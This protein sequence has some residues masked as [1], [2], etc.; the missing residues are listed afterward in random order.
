MVRHVSRNPNPNTNGPNVPEENLPVKQLNK[1]GTNFEAMNFSYV[2]ILMFTDSHIKKIL[3][4]GSSVRSSE[5]MGRI[6]L[7][8]VIFK[9]NVCRE[10]SKG[11]Y[12]SILLHPMIE[13]FL[14][15]Y[16]YYRIASFLRNSSPKK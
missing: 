15:L 11:A 8:Q 10:V 16:G 3:L 5:G 4:Y 7:K 6:P 14:R 1:G 9:V 12:L 13:L 2:R